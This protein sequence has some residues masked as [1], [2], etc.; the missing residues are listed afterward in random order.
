MASLPRVTELGE[1]GSMSDF[2]FPVTSPQDLPHLVD[3]LRA[4][5][6]PVVAG[7]GQVLR[8]ASQEDEDEFSQDILVSSQLGQIEVA[9]SWDKGRG[10]AEV[11]VSAASGSRRAYLPLAFA[12]A[13]AFLADRTPELLPV[14]R[15]LRVMLGVVAGTVVGLLVLA[16]VSA[17][18][19]RRPRSD[20]GLQQNVE[21][22]VQSVLSQRGTPSTSREL[23]EA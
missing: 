8:R 14:F 1:N 22:A 23:L 16:V 15:G 9:V 10:D 18:T 20:D 19:P 5:L 7:R 21:R 3:Q 6:Q 2:R 12:F 11:S 13:A 4:A 17:F